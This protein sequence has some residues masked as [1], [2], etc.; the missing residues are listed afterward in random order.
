VAVSRPGRSLATRRLRAQAGGEGKK[1]EPKLSFQPSSRSGLGFTDDDSAGQSNIFAVE[2]KVVVSDSNTSSNV[3]G[4][5]IA[6]AV[7]IGLVIAGLRILT[8]GEAADVVPG[9]DAGLKSLT[10]YASE[11]VVVDGSRAAAGAGADA[12]PDLM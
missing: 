1:Q 4:P 6:G 7:A 10:A 12:A 2:P 9:P 5:A 11:L 3:G 8:D